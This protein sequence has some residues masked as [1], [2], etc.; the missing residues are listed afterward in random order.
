MRDSSGYAVGRYGWQNADVEATGGSQP[1]SAV[2]PHGERRN[3]SGKP[4][5]AAL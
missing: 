2:M 1:S 5:P 3:K 4:D